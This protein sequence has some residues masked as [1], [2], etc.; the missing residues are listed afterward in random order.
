MFGL[1]KNKIAI[2]LWIYPCMQVLVHAASYFC[3]MY[4]CM[5]TYVCWYHEWYRRFAVPLPYHTHVDSNTIRRV[6][7]E[8][9]QLETVVFEKP[10]TDSSRHHHRSVGGGPEDEDPLLLVSVAQPRRCASSSPSV[11]VTRA[12]MLKGSPIRLIIPNF[13]S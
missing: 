10:I 5:I 3:N 9:P 13:V 12:P 2:F 8:M 1:N 7:Q 11:M 4:F 6:I